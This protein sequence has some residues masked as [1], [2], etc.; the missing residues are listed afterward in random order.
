MKYKSITLK[1][2]SNILT[3]ND[4]MLNVSQIAHIIDQVAALRRTGIEIIIVSSGAV[5]AGRGE[6]K[7]NKNLDAV[8]ARQ[9]YSAIGQVKLMRRY[10]DLFKEHDIACAQVLATKSD[11]SDR[12]HYL[13]MRNCIRTMLENN[14]I[15]IINENDT[16]SISELMFTDN[17]ELSGM[18]ACMQKSEALIMLSNVDGIYNGNPLDR[19]SKLIETIEAKDKV[20]MNN[21]SRQKSGFGRGGM[22]TKGS[23]AQ[24]VAKQG[25]DVHI[26][27][28]A[29]KNIILDLLDS[30]KKVEH[31]TFVAQKQNPSDVKRWLALSN[32]F[33]KA[34][35]TV[36]DGAREALISEQAT[37]LLLVGVVRTTGEFKKGDIIKIKDE[38]GDLI[39]WGKA[40][41]S[42]ST[43]QEKLGRKYKQAIIH[44]DYLYLK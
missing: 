41:I 11:F 13:N 25:I 34:E 22:L 43:A 44:Y 10:T 26:A 37:S 40:N 16:I 12:E 36:N 18:I 42:S 33:A 39:G 28:G 27:N 2:G 8:S 15:P 5:A 24:Q 3:R 6:L 9:L 23:I 32:S 17:D 29:Q 4:G 30:D 19:S 20:W 7:P 14:V 35:L 31:T 1:I 38:K 21:V